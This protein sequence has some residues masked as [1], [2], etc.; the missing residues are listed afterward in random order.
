MTTVTVRSPSM[1]PGRVPALGHAMRMKRRP[2]DFMLSLQSGD[3]VTMVKLGRKLMYVVNDPELIRELQRNT[4]IYGRGGPITERFR[5]MFGNGLGISEGDFHRHQRSLIQPAF[6]HARIVEYA[7]HMSALISA[8]MNSWQ[9]GQCLAVDKEMDDLALSV[10][11]DVI[12]SAHAAMDRKQFMAATTEVLGGLFRRITDSTGMLT[13]IPTPA[14]RRYRKAEKY[15]HST[16]H[17]VIAEYRAS[18]A[19]RGDLLSTM[20]LARDA[21]G[22]HSMTAEQ[23]HDEVVTFFI[24]GSNT[25]SNTLS[26]S[27]HELATH[28]DVETRL[29]AE[30]DQVLATRP[31]EYD[32]LGKLDYTRRVISETLRMRTQGLFL[33]KVTVRDT[34]LGGYHIPAGVPVLYSFH[35]LNHNATIYSNPECFD[36]DRWHPDRI[37]EIPCG[38]FMPFGVGPHGCIGEQFSWVEMIISLATIAA[39][40]HLVSVPGHTPRPKPAITMPV[41]S[42]PMIA[43]RR[44]VT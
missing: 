13:R 22:G 7:S 25:I 21:D 41:D 44:H 29:H 26:W 36:P 31:A 1:A 11:T 20:L 27:L 18:G 6:R 33:S 35:A 15:L 9:D 30:V 34:E 42:L 16:I 8:K 19:D 37:G 14:N 12:F 28:P 39:R 43:H 24:A 10:V 17:E 40:W 23:V 5:Q 4:R 3:P 32:D 2:G 38:A